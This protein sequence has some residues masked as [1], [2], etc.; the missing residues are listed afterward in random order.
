[1]CKTPQ[2]MKAINW[3]L[4]VLYTLRLPKAFSAIKSPE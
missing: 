3:S 4:K 2:Q 1:M